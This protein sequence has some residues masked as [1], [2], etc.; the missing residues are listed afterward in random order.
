MNKT[1]K[2]LIRIVKMWNLLN[3]LKLKLKLKLNHQKRRE[4]S[5]TNLKNVKIMIIMR[6]KMQLS[7]EILINQKKNKVEHSKNI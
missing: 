2:L 1:K 4:I 6:L 7:K 5:S 3:R